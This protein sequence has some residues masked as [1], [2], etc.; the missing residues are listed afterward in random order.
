MK[1]LGWLLVA[2]LVVLVA[3]VSGAGEEFLHSFGDNSVEITYRNETGERV[4]VS[5]YGRTYPASERLL[6]PG[7]VF[8][9]DLLSSNPKPTTVITR[10][11]AFDET[12]A[13]IY[14]HRFTF[15]E[16]QSLNGQVAIRVGDN[17]C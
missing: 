10:L 11:E 3:I 13:L 2:G 1:T 14:C 5:P 12:G 6:E 7:A 17:T 8:R 9:D 16:L 15:R 4:I